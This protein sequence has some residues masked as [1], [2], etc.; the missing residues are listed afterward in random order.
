MTKKIFIFALVA[1]LALTTVF[2]SGAR[3]K[4]VDFQALDMETA[5][6]SDIQMTWNA[7]VNNYNDNVQSLQSAMAEAYAERNAKEYTESRDLLRSLVAPVVTKEQTETLMA[8]AASASEEEQKAIVTFLSSTSA[9]YRNPKVTFSYSYEGEGRKSSFKSSV[10]RL[11]GSVFNAPS[12]SAGDGKFVGWADEDG[13][14]IC[15][16]GEEI[17]MP[18]VDTVYYAVFQSGIT[19]VDPISGTESFVE[20]SSAALP[21]P[22]EKEGLLFVGW[23]NQNG[24][25]QDGDVVLSEGRSATLTAGWIGLEIDTVKEATVPSNKRLGMAVRLNSLGNVSMNDVSVTL[26]KVDGLEIKG[27]GTLSTK[28]LGAKSYVKGSYEIMVTGESGAV[29][30]TAIT[31]KAADGHEWSSPNVFTVK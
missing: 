8:R 28:R 30:E 21:V 26:E 19:F 7:A 11:P 29:I 13:T 4:L 16:A 14:I 23:Y 17:S 22:E 10:S 2:A 6:M 20:G 15:Q 1:F 31:V 25:L 3:E 12:C 27:S 5:S 18:Y 9:Y 24:S